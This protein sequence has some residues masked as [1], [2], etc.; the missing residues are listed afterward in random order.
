MTDDRMSDDVALVL[1]TFRDA[2]GKAQEFGLG[3]ISLGDMLRAEDGHLSAFNRILAA[4]SA[5]RAEVDRLLT[6]REAAEAALDALVDAA[7]LMV[8]HYCGDGPCAAFGG[9]NV[10]CNECVTPRAFKAALAAL[11][12]DPKDG[13]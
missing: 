3:N 8:D 12:P 11:S 9:K 13:E 7:W 1:A 4:L 5:E 10:T 6:E 2:L